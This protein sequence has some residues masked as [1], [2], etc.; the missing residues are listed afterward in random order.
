MVIAI[1][2]LITRATEEDIDPPGMAAELQLMED[3]AS[4]VNLLS[5]AL[6]GGMGSAKLGECSRVAKRSPSDW[7]SENR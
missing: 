6:E 5:A 7:P 3:V 4:K 2:E 1:T